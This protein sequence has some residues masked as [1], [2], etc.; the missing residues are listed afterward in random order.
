MPPRGQAVPGHHH[1]LGITAQPFRVL[2]VVS[3]G[4]LN[5]P[6]LRERGLDCVG[7][8]IGIKDG[9]G[10]R[11]CQKDGAEPPLTQPVVTFL[12]THGVYRFH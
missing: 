10:R 9:K 4:L 5:R 7:G 11:R 12:N 2:P 1:R 8:S 6:S 3:D